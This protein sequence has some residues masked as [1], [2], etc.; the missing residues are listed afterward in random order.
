[1]KMRALNQKFITDLK[2]GCHSGITNEVRNDDSLM[3]CLRGDYVTVY[4]KSMRILEISEN[5]KYNIDRHY[6]APDPNKVADWGEYF[7][8]AK[9]AID[10]YNTNEKL[11]KEIQQMIARENTCCSISNAT[12][13]F[14]FDIEY[15]QADKSL[16]DGRFDALA[17]HWP[18]DKRRND[19]DL[20]IAFIE[21]KVGEKAIL[22]SSGLIKH[23]NS[24]S[25]FI[26][27]LKQDTEYKKSFLDDA[28]QVVAQLR[29][30]GL[31]KIND[32][33]NTISFADEFYPQMIF[34][35]ADFNT[36]SEILKEP[37][38]SIQHNKE[39]FDL[40]FA[41]SSFMG[42]ALYDECMLTLDET[43]EKLG[44]KNESMY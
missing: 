22:G 15:T 37:L 34:I 40:R 19:K 41:T 20:Q 21:I 24:A 23:Y 44:Y 17:V 31:W 16:A 13:Y 4:Y 1:M 36:H 10:S 42:Y 25:N 39:L 43:K 26:E 7:K 32:N 18:R 12:D 8:N 33:K 14:I 5:G 29:E 38:Q 2:S 6:G 9:K 3:I 27:R 35:L 30:L 28:A 11:E